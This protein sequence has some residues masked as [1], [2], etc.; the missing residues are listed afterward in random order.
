MHP[1]SLL[2]E[3]TADAIDSFEMLLRSATLNATGTNA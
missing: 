2:S 3:R 1:L